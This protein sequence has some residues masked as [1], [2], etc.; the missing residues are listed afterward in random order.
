[1][2]FKKCAFQLLTYFKKKVSHS[3]FQ[4]KCDN[5]D[6]MN[7]NLKYLKQER[8]FFHFIDGSIISFQLNLHFCQSH[9]FLN[10]IGILGVSIF[11]GRKN[12]PWLEAISNF[13][14]ES[15]GFIKSS[16]TLPISS[17]DFGATTI[18][19]S[20]ETLFFIDCKVVQRWGKNISVRHCRLKYPIRETLLKI[21]ITLS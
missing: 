7:L 1:M 4:C 9:I 6:C 21:Y 2:L 10:F 19:Q 13:L 8:L 5:R 16:L 18:H 11:T 14:E 17:F 3:M 12:L 15:V 20:Y